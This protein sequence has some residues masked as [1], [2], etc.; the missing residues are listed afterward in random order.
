[1]SKANQVRSFIAD[2]KAEHAAPTEQ[3]IVL[4]MDACGFRRQLA[5]AYINN[6]WDKV[7]PAERAA[8]VVVEAAVLNEAVEEAAARMTFE[9]ALATIPLR[10][11]GR[12]IAKA[13]REERARALLQEQ[14]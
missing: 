14:A 11:K 4:V 6:N 12:F 7:Q 10:E 5:R 9:E 13:V 3:L 8:I 2:C 1:M